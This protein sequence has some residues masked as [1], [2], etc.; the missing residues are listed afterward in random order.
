MMNKSLFALFAF[1]IAPIVALADAP[2]LEV[3]VETMPMDNFKHVK[4]EMV[5]IPAGEFECKPGRDAE[6]QK[7]AVKNG[8]IGKHE[9]TWDEFDIFAFGLDIADEKAKQ[10]S[11]GVPRPSK[12]YAAPDYGFGH[13]GF[14][15][16]SIHYR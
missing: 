1:V 8:W 9:V 15:A 12:P 11:V 3:R 10:E 6:P 4:W 13:H 5:K 14:A 16:I 7:V 2:K